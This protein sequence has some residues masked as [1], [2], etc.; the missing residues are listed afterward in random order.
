MSLKIKNNINSELSIEHNDGSQAITVSSEELSK[1]KT[2]NIVNLANGT[3]P[4]SDPLISGQLW[5][6]AGIVTVSTGA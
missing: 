6:N 2:D 3:L 1:V 4:T 5:N